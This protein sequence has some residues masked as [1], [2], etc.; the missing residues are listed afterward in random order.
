[1]LA[2]LVP[3]NGLTSAQYLVKAMTY[4]ATLVAAG[5]V[6]ARVSLGTLSVDGRASLA[7]IAAV[8]TPVA[9]RR[10]ALGLSCED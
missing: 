6:L 8:T 10:T 4:A 1:M 2:L 9:A 5:S 7:R 3:A